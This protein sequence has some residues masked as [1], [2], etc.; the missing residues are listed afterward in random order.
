MMKRFFSV[1]ICICLFSCSISAFAAEHT[2]KA[3]ILA[4]LGLFR[5]TDKG[6]EL[7]LT[8]TRAQSA[9]MLV[10]LLGKEETALSA[11][12]ASRFTDVP[13]EHWAAKYVMYCYENGITKGTGEDTFTPEQDI[14]AE[15][16][17]TLVLRL[18]GYEADP[19]TAMDIAV[20]V[21]LFST[22]VQRNLVGKPFLR[23]DM[24]YIAY[25]ALKTLCA[26]GEALSEKLIDGGVI[27]AAN[28]EKHGVLHYGT[29]ADS[30]DDVIADLFD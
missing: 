28:A 11:S 29:T 16:F 22:D 26:D 2:D 24:V 17:V 6:Y 13:D 25:R 18:L 10:R 15:Q 21:E 5:G 8:L 12:T 23:D 30:I 9:T 7:E 14:P 19:E 3:D 27:T 20:D 1:V 4:E